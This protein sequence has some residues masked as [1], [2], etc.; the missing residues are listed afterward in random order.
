MS[1]RQVLDT[2]RGLL[3]DDIVG[4]KAK[5]DALILADPPESI[6]RTDFHFIRWAFSTLTNPTQKPN[7]IVRPG[8][9]RGD[10]M[11]G[12][13]QRDAICIVE[14]GYEQ[15]GTDPDEIEDG[16]ALI[17][18]ALPRCVLDGLRAYSDAHGGTIVDVIDPIEVQFG[19]FA[20]A[21]SSGFLARV[22]VLER[23]ST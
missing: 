13:G 23:S 22:T 20:G 14:I 2:V 8:S 10:E 1:M 6:V 7:V 16:L 3:K 15:F 18:A 11:L 5:A 19:E 9:W 4:L 17:A 12:T 21:A